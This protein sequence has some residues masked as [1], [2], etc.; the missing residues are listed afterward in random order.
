VMAGF[1]HND[2][3][4]EA[5][6]TQASLAPETLARRPRLLRQAQSPGLG[7]TVRCVSVVMV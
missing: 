2:R 1:V 6:M 3:L 5:L 7:G 4:I